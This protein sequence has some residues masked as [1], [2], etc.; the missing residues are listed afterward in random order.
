M[1]DFTAFDKARE[2]YN[3]PPLPFLDSA[4]DRA[5]EERPY[6]GLK[7]LHNVPLTLVTAVKIEVLAL[8]GASVTS[9]STSFFSPEKRAVDLLQQAKLTIDLQPDSVTE[10][11]FHLDCCAEL[12]SRRAPKM[13]SIE[14]TQ[15]GSKR[16]HQALLDYPVLSVDDSKLKILE[17][18]L[19]T[20]DGFARALYQR[21]RD[22]MRGKAFVVFGHGKVGRGIV[23]ALKQF[24][25]DITVIDVETKQAAR[26]PQV[27]YIDAKNKALVKEA[28]ANAYCAITATGIKHLISE[29]YGL[30]K[31]DFGDCILTNMGAD[32]EYGDYFDTS[33]VAFDKK[34][35]NFSLEE[36]T[37]FHYLDP[38]FYS[39][40]LGIDLILSKQISHG[41][42]AF[43]HDLAQGILQ[44]WQGIYNENLDEALRA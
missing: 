34:P 1:Y 7:I 20:G 31:R 38:V 11:D 21:V 32:D 36:P 4:R 19:G 35:L 24:T 39:H 6:Q 42:N 33:D 37:A 3:V 5:R 12:L 13:G 27:R 40:N 26:C 41:Y 8:G 14:L 16:Y 10:F 9:M 25:Q 43:P 29:Y 23:H 22:D 15:T 44:K 17:T 30:K 2:R 18:F 28:I